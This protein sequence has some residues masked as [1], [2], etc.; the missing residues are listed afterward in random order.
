MDDHQHIWIQLD[1]SV[2]FD[3]PS[4]QVCPICGEIELKPDHRRFPARV[5]DEVLI[6]A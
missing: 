2:Y 3:T 6:A 5:Q 1:E 4:L